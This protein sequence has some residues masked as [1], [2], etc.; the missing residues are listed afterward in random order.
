[1]N[2]TTLLFRTQVSADGRINFPSPNIQFSQLEEEPR[3]NKPPRKKCWSRFSFTE[4]LIGIAA[5]SPIL[6]L[7][8]WCV[9]GPHTLESLVPHPNWLHPPY[10]LLKGRVHLLLMPDNSFWWVNYKGELG[11]N[12]PGPTSLSNPKIADAYWW[13]DHV[14]T[15]TNKGWIDPEI[16]E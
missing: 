12:S 4:P 14:W 6:V 7:A 5:M 15:Y 1:M 10:Q 11:E 13:R 9:F 16:V 2:T 3:R 8:A